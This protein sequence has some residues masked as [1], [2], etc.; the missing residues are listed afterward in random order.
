MVSAIREELREREAPRHL[1]NLNNTQILN[2]ETPQK[3]SKYK[4]ARKIL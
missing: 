1:I 3:M 4:Q 2:F